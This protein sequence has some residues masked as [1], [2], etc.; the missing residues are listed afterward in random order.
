[1]TDRPDLRA[2]AT[3]LTAVFKPF[4]DRVSDLEWTSKDGVLGLIQRRRSAHAASPF[5]PLRR[6]ET[7]RRDRR[8][9][10]AIDIATARGRTVRHMLDSPDTEVDEDAEA[11]WATEVNRRLAEL[12]AGAV[13]TIPG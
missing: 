11:A 5:A 7:R 12:D 2:C 4:V 13:K 8:A 3:E 6:A 1:M 9:A 10:G